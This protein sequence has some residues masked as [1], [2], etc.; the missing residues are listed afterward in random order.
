MGCISDQMIECWDNPMSEQ[1]PR[2]LLVMGAQEIRRLRRAVEAKD[3]IIRALHD[4]NAEMASLLRNS[5]P[6]PDMPLYLIGLMAVAVIAFAVCT[7]F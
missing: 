3:N 4:T 5:Q 7:V 1:D 2:N 6:D